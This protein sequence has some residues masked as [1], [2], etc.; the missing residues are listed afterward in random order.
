MAG[1]DALADEKLIQDKIAAYRSLEERINALVGQQA[2]FASK[3]AEIQSTLAAIDELSEGSGDA[4]FP[5]GT[6]VYAK[7]KFDASAKLLVEVGAGVAVERTAAEAKLILEARNKDI[8]QAIE[9]LQKD[10]RTV[11][12]ML[13]R[14]EAE[15]QEMLRARGRK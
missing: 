12:G 5:L 4:L 2:T 8:E 15:A 3:A 10:V 6:A 7:G 1:N 14:I 13:Q 9:V 11:A